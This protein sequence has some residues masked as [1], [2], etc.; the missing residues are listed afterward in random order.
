M[1]NKLGNWISSQDLEAQAAAHAKAKTDAL[2]AAFHPTATV[3]QQGMP[4]SSPHN[5][6][7]PQNIKAGP[8]APVDYPHMPPQEDPKETALKEAFMSVSK[9]KDK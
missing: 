7:D 9:K 8:P 3:P 1:P 4:A 2:A 6:P 5:V